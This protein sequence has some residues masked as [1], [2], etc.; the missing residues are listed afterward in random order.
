MSVEIK[1]QKMADGTTVNTCQLTESNFNDVAYWCNGE[2]YHPETGGS[3]IVLEILG[4]KNPRFEKAYLGHWIVSEEIGFVIYNDLG[5]RNRFGDYDAVEETPEPVILNKWR[6]NEENIR[7]VAKWCGGVW[8]N[9]GQYGHNFINIDADKLSKLSKGNSAMIGDWIVRL[10]DGFIIMN[11]EDYMALDF[12]RSAYQVRRDTMRQ[13]AEWC[14]GIAQDVSD[15]VFCVQINNPIPFTKAVCAY[16]GDWIVRRPDGY[17]IMSQDDYVRYSN[18]DAP[19][20]KIVSAQEP[21][22]D[23]KTKQY[24]VDLLI[25]NAFLSIAPSTQQDVL[26]RVLDRT[27]SEIS[28]LF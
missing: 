1:P 15:E 3:F 28:K 17:Q 26:R 10:E 13:V 21:V 12:G 5:Y 8:F 20:D 2:V 23:L 9:F 11:D 16:D 14:G 7:E 18:P 24:I 4:H 27:T 22:L 19:M 25:R 6:I